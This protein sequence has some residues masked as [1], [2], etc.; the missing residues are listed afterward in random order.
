MD[1]QERARKERSRSQRIILVNRV[2]ALDGGVTCTILGTSGVAFSVVVD[3]DKKPQCSCP[4]FSR[5]KRRCKHLYFCL[6]QILRVSDI[7]KDKYTAAEIGGA[8]VTAAVSGPAK[9]KALGDDVCP[10]CMEEFEEGGSEPL[11]WCS[12]TC[13]TNFHQECFVRYMNFTTKSKCPMC[14]SDVPM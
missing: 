5:R 6:E 11:M 3:P 9:R 7:D 2:T 12:Q 13:G 14:R 1:H 10:F 8:K 4:D